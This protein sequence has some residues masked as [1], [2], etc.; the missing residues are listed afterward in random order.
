MRGRFD[1]AL[2]TS[3]SS[4]VA[5]EETLRRIE[6]YSITSIRSSADSLRS[7]DSLRTELS[8]LE[9]MITSSRAPSTT[10]I[11]QYD[12]GYIM[13]TSGPENRPT[14]GHEVTSKELVDC[15]SR[16]SPGSL[17]S[18]SLRARSS[19][20]SRR[21]SDVSG[22]KLANSYENISLHTHP[23]EYQSLVREQE[24]IS[25]RFSEISDGYESALLYAQFSRTASPVEAGLLHDTSNINMHQNGFQPREIIQGKISPAGGILT[26]PSHGQF[27][28]F[29]DIP[30]DCSP[31]QEVALRDSVRTSISQ[32]VDDRSSSSYEQSS[33]ANNLP[34]DSDPNAAYNLLQQCLA[35]THPPIVADYL[36]LLD[37]I[38]LYERHSR[39]L[40]ERQ[41]TTI[42]G[43]AHAI[44]FDD[45]LAQSH[46]RKLR[47]RLEALQVAADNAAKKCAEGGYSVSELEK[48]SLPMKRRDPVQ[49]PTLAPS[50]N[51]LESRDDED[52]S[53]D[54]F[55]DDSDIY[56]SSAE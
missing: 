30:R 29:P 50:N 31:T 35:A 23:A 39:I 32:R 54:S 20:K 27:R 18:Q 1:D 52:A 43:T 47:D 17:T 3:L 34:V 10:R 28:G 13:R 26:S 19:I 21:S 2:T 11:E 49:S 16:P 36:S 56:F 42:Y 9:A 40:E 46:L 14:L 38:S 4:H 51:Q 41:N 15:V 25:K 48:I 8:R 55:S 37:L 45:V 33:I 6:R 5:H 24:D 12:E 22:A 53:D 44:G 7:V